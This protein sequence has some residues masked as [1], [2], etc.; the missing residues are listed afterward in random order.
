MNYWGFSCLSPATGINIFYLSLPKITWNRQVDRYYFEPWSCVMFFSP[1]HAV[2]S[3]ILRDEYLTSVVRTKEGDKA[4]SKQP[5]GCDPV[6]FKLELKPNYLISYLENTKIS[7][8]K[9]SWGYKIS[10]LNMTGVKISTKGIWGAHVDSN[11]P[12]SVS[13]PN[14]HP[15]G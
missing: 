3:A 9:R 5:Q 4:G 11:P 13:R 2:L 7:Q 10:F 12:I 1:S 15:C 14:K 8:K 6:Q